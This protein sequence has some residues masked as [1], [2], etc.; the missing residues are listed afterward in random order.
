VI[1]LN[2][3]FKNYNPNS[4]HH[5]AA[6]NCLMDSLPEDLLHRSAEWVSI[7]NASETDWGYNKDK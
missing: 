2:R 6:V 1:D 7:W 3:F 5:I 4:S